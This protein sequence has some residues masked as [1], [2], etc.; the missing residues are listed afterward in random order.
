MRDFKKLFGD[1]SI[2]SHLAFPFL[3]KI[4]LNFLFYRRLLPSIENISFYLKS[5]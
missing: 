3:S 4:V 2:T 5:F 1:R